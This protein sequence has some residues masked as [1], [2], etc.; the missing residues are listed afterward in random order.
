VPYECW[1]AEDIRRHAPGLDTG[2]YGPPKAVTDD[3]FWGDA[4]GQLEAYYTPD[5]GFVDDPQLAA[6]NLAEA[7][8]RA[9]AEILLGEEV[10]ALQRS[11]TR[12]RGV[13]L[14]SGTRI[15]APVVVNVAGPHSGQIN[16]L[17][18]VLD[19]FRVRTRPL[20]QEVHSLAAP[21]DFGR[22]DLGPV[23]MDGDLGT[24][25]RPH[26]G[27]QVIV[28]G[29]EPECD[30]LDWMEDPDAY[31]P[32]ATVP[33]WEAQVT[34]LARRIPSLAVPARPRGLGALYDVSD[35]W[36][37]IYDRT[38]L[39]GFYVAI[40]TSGNQF[41]NAPVVGQFMAELIGSCESGHD[42]DADPVVVRTPY[43]GQLLGLGH[44]SRLREPHADSTFSV[45]G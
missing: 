25:F 11:D 4:A 5:A 16:V 17:A 40:G 15:D 13:G 1:D 9:G 42:H 28:G 44:Y 8:R 22:S 34:R 7:A 35:D 18:G 24:Y 26:P 2:R 41:K 36:I 12:V 6:R 21:A 38:A 39:G 30:P 31:R 19:E 43:T 10:T 33:V 45:M 29:A 23:V 3:A 14:R 27:G 20:R 37:P 32:N